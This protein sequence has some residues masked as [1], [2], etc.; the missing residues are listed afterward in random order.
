MIH[1]IH[2]FLQTTPHDF[3]EKS[4]R[5][6]VAG[7]TVS[8]Q[9]LKPLICSGSDITSSAPGGFST[10]KNKSQAQN[11]G[12]YPLAFLEAQELR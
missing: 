1:I 5:L 11:E 6:R 8:G 2:A 12:R 10:Q 4:S 7:K 9:R 3:K